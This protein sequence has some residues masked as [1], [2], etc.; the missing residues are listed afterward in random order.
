MCVS[1]Y[2]ACHF[3]DSH[4]NEL[5]MTICIIAESREL[6]LKLEPR[7]QILMAGGMGRMVEPMDTNS[8]AKCMTFPV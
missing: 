7:Y 4:Q 6:E 3:F 8:N 2:R 1:T 5:N